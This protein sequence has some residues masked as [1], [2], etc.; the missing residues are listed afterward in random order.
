M[1]LTLKCNNIKFGLY[2]EDSA[3]YSSSFLVI[4][5]KND[6]GLNSDEGDFF[7]GI[8][9]LLKAFTY[10]KYCLESKK[11][12]PIIEIVLDMDKDNEDA[13][14]LHIN[15]QF[16]TEEKAFDTMNKL[17]KGLETAVKESDIRDK[18][19]KAEVEK[20]IVGSHIIEDI[21]FISLE[22]LYYGIKN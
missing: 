22:S 21:K 3:T 20:Q 10:S 4:N 13:F 7:I 15:L 16:E 19:L 12:I 8:T 9:D 18:K 11:D 5:P 14:V 1:I 17:Y 2:Q 6:F